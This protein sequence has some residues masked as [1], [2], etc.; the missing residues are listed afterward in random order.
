MPHEYQ[1]PRDMTVAPAPDTNV[2]IMQKLADSYDEVERKPVLRDTTLVLQTKTVGQGDQKRKMNIY[3]AFTYVSVTRELGLNPLMNHVIFLEGQTYITL[4]GHLQNAHA[5]G[6]LLGLECEKLSDGEV[7][8]TKR[9][10]DAKKD[11]QAKGRQ[12]R[13]RC[14]ITR[15]MNGEI[16]KFSAEGIADPSNVTGKGVSEM[17]LEQMAEARAMRRCLSRAF[18]VGIA[19]IEDIQDEGTL[20]TYNPNVLPSEDRTLGSGALA[21]EIEACETL[22]ELDALKTKLAQSGRNDLV[23]VWAKR[24]RAISSIESA[25]EV[26]TKRKYTKRAMTHVSEID[27]THKFADTIP[28]D[29]TSTPHDTVLATASDSI[30]EKGIND[31]L[32]SIGEKIDRATETTSHTESTDAVSEKATEKEKSHEI[33]STPERDAVIQEVLSAKSS[34]ELEA[35]RIRSMEHLLQGDYGKIERRIDEFKKREKAATDTDAEGIF[36]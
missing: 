31:N 9:D 20:Q 12:F 5:S 2:M 15:K 7:T 26:P 32:A 36:E 4:Q 17:K 21:D 18:P 14:T 13:Y 1:E 3:E 6:T 19:N 35:I 11:V 29:D 22:E 28:D 8:Y 24:K 10:W 33:V 30:S 16:A 25:E 27:E 23:A 34:S